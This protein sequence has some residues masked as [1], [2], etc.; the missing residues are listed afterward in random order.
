[1]SDLANDGPNADQ[2]K[3]WNG[4]GGEQWAINQE[5]MDANLKPFADAAIALADAKPGERALD[6]GCGCG[7]TTLVLAD[8]VGLEG[9]AI[10]LDISGPMIA[11]ANER[12]AAVETMGL[13]C[14]GFVLG[15]AS[16]YAFKPA[17]TD[18]L[19]SRFGVMFFSDPT[20]AFANMRGALR[21]G[22]RTAFI[23][24]QPMAL[25]DFFMVPTAAALTV[26][27]AP[28]APPADAPGPFAFGDKDRLNRVLTDAG[29]SGISI[30][31]LEI[32]MEVGGGKGIEAAGREL[33]RTGPLARMVIDLSDE[34]RER[35]TD[36]VIQALE[37][38]ASGGKVSLGSRTWL[39]S[40][41]SS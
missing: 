16:S 25:N 28:E 14:P 22:G 1:M 39:V 6:I 15:D 4:P 3:F 18:L 2:I 41:K 17:Q 40:A 27:P 35:V 34:L 8:K 13:P 37:A 21:P 30:D 10:G 29:F 9:R 32:D 7:D 12:A 31:S 38:H 5:N 23:C 11:R 26:L 36:A 24:W 19:F 20:A 33:T